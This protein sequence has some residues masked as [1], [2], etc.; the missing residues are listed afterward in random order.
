M[1]RLKRTREIVK[2]EGRFLM[3][4]ARFPSDLFQKID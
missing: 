1:H 4:H 3:H 2:S